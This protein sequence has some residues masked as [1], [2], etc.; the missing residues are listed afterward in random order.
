MSDLV[1]VWA[2]NRFTAQL[3]HSALVANGLEAELDAAT[4]SGAYPVTVGSMGEG[5][6]FV[7]RDDASEAMTIIRELETEDAAETDTSEADED[8]LPRRLN[9]VWFWVALAILIVSVIVWIVNG[10]PIP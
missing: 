7:R 1:E 5:R 4:S 9:P 10:F 3:V 2:G 8:E 6:V